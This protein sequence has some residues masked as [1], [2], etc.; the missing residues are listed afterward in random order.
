MATNQFFNQTVRS[1]DSLLSNKA[2]QALGGIDN[3]VLRNAAGSL[4]NAFLPGL[5]GGPYSYNDTVYANTVNNRIA[6]IQQQ[7]GLVGDVA[8][9]TDA[10]SE[11]SDSYDWRARLR[12]KNGGIKR[13]YSLETGS[14]NLLEPI[15]MSGGLIWQYTPSLTMTGTAN[16]TQ[17]LLHGMNYPINTY[18]N[19]SPPELSV[20]SDFTANDIT[21]ARYLLAVMA[22]LRICT[23]SHFGDDSVA[24]GT[25]GLP[26]PVLLFEY[27]GDHGFNKVP[28]VVSSWTMQLADD[29][30]YVPVQ[31]R[32]TI[33]YV[34]SK[35][36]ITITL[37]PTYAPHKVRSRFSLE[38]VT[39]G[40]A[41]KDGFI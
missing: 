9:Y 1:I 34:P 38:S 22:F 37:L 25:F 27:L 24:R 2:G 8:V 33:T 30:D 15:K 18:N 36:N 17:T 28:V 11:L 6:E 35:T 16:Y 3:P 10:S 12:P 5:A 40:S 4:V 23:K 26:P 7:T 13:F 14:A 19:S 20:S 32:D 29:V 41:Y 39:N 31:V 21:E